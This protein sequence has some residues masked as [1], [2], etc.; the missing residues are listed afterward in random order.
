MGP[1]GALPVERAWTLEFAPGG[2]AGGAQ[3]RQ[4]AAGR[5]GEG[6]GGGAARGAGVDPGVRPRRFEGRVYA[7]EGV[8]GPQELFGEEVDVLE[9]ANEDLGLPVEGAARRERAPGVRAASRTLV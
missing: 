5:R 2:S 8:D 9:E 3:P 4:A 7:E 6:A 1:A